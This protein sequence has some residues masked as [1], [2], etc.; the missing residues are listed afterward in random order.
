M[1]RMSLPYE[2]DL[3]LVRSPRRGFFCFFLVPVFVLSYVP[4]A[5]FCSFRSFFWCALCSISLIAAATCLVC[6]SFA[7]RFSLVA[8][9]SLV[10][11]GWLVNSSNCG[12]SRSSGK[13]LSFMLFP[14][15]SLLW[16]SRLVFLSGIES[17]VADRRCCFVPNVVWKLLFLGSLC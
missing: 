13:S 11:F 17:C 7:E 3:L 1:T 2:F 6:S 12:F 14:L 8:S 15:V 16:P 10:S 5:F 9:L 4:F